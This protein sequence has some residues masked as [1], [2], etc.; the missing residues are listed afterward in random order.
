[1]FNTLGFKKMKIKSTIDTT[2]HLLQWLKL[3]RLTTATA[4]R[5][6]EKLELSCIAGGEYKQFENNLA[7]SRK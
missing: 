5:D 3:K 1:M 6:V 4:N 7:A 2:T